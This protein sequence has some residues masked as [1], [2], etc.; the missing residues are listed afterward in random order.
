MVGTF[1]RLKAT[2]LRNSLRG[3]RLRVV[4]TVAGAV[5]GLLAAVLGF[6]VLFGAAS[7]GTLTGYV[8]AT[9]VTGLIGLGWFVMPVLFFGVD[10]TL[11]PAKFGLLPIPRRRLIAGM[12]AAASLGVPA[13]A[14]AVATT[15]LV[16]G[17]LRYGV[18]AT[19]VAAVGV[20][21]G[22]AVF[23]LGSRAVTSGFAAVLRSRKARDA[24]LLGVVVMLGLIGP[25][26]L[27]TIRSVNETGV[28]ALRPFA[29]VVA[30]TP[31]A[32]PYAA[33]FDVVT[34]KLGLAL[35]RLGVG[36]LAAVAL[37]VWWGRSLEAAMLGNSRGSQSTAR[38]VGELVPRPLRGLVTTGPYGAVLA[39]E[40]RLWWRDP[41]YRAGLA[42]FGLAS[43]MLPLTI[44]LTGG[45]GLSVAMLAVLGAVG[46]LA[47]T[48]VANTFGYDGRAYAVH[49]L[50]AVPAR[51]DLRAR[52]S[53][54]A[55]IVVP[56]LAAVA[57][58]IAVWC[59]VPGEAPPTA[60]LMLACFGV[61]LGVMTVVAGYVA[62]PLP[63]SG[64]P[65]GMGSGT[66][67]TNIAIQLLGFLVIGL[68][69]APLGYLALEL[70]E[71]APGFLWV[72]LPL[73]LGYA[74][75]VA[76]AGV[77][78]AAARVRRH[79]PELLAAVTPRR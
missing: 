41:R 73:G 9:L 51:T 71:F 14:T 16:A 45:R 28:T 33:L 6:L 49:L 56:V 17:A 79:G 32:A 15:G 22:L 39:R 19:L 46:M 11:D 5:V 13:I 47:A 3:N 42:S 38:R 78:I 27:L 75:G 1:V 29:D 23:V 66:G 70:R 8:A 18:L 74:F 35:A 76:E 50:T 57:T 63:A 40:L 72:V 64:N 61:G 54:C 24:A 34:G 62:Y 4:S 26:E 12:F 68:L 37:W 77:R 2:I 30:W 20:I 10:D 55:V 67:F 21:V 25:M 7:S 69:V 59:G 52:L 60:G 65:F 44:V 48:L 36:V 43:V 53:A 58:V 31:F